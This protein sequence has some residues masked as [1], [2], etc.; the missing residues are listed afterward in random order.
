MQSST[1]A[2]GHAQADGRRYVTE[3]HIDATG[4]RHLVEYGPVPEI[5]YA[6]TLA[7][8]AVAL[9]AALA[10][11]ELSHCI[12]SGSVRTQYQTAGQFAARF[13]ERYRAAGREEAA[14]LATWII[15]RIT[16][17]QLPDLQVRT[18]FGL[19]TTQYNALKTRWTT[20][21]TQWLAIQSAAGE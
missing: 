18:A 7:A 9:D 13:R 21:R 12:T 15:D 20:L 14:R 3:T 19:T 10:D 17:G 5:D 16:A 8:R 11:D 1:H 2:T 4:A 6:A